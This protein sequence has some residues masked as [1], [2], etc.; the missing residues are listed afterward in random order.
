[1]NKE[2]ETAE[3]KIKATIKDLEHYYRSLEYGPIS[4][5]EGH[6]LQILVEFSN[7]KNVLEI[8]TS[9][10][11]SSLWIALGLLQ[12]KG[13]LITIEAM[14]EHVQC[15][16]ENFEKAGAQDLITIIDGN[17]LDCIPLIEG[18]FDII[19]LDSAKNEYLKLFNLFFHLLR[20]KGIII[21][22]D[23]ICEKHKMQDYLDVVEKHPQLETV[24]IS[25]NENTSGMAVSYKKSS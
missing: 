17:A 3:N 22:H 1:M 15:A 25:F 14:R 5:E 19:F 6:L 11:V 4:G 24:V 13:S 12:T 10:G 16:R 21:A 8:G 9:M 23:A 7:A 18:K 20:D 2:I